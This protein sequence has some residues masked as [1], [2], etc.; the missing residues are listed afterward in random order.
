MEPGERSEMLYDAGWKIPVWNSP[1]L[2]CPSR[3]PVLK[4]EW[5]TLRTALPKR[6][7]TW[8]VTENVEALNFEIECGIQRWMNSTR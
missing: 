3:E 6:Y 4:S 5:E 1:L 8:T 2:F 7:D